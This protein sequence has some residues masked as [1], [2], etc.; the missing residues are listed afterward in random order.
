MEVHVGGINIMDT[1]IVQVHVF[2]DSRLTWWEVLWYDISDAKLFKN[3]RSF[4]VP[5]PGLLSCFVLMLASSVP[6]G[7]VR[8]ARMSLQMFRLCGK[9]L[10][11]RPLSFFFFFLKFIENSIWLWTTAAT[12]RS[13]VGKRE[14]EKNIYT[15]CLPLHVHLLFKQGWFAASQFPWLGYRRQWPPAQQ[16]SHDGMC[17]GWQDGAGHSILVGC[18]WCLITNPGSQTDFPP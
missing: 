4:R 2:L 6:F 14:N 9:H 15:R 10:T 8:W 5:Q 18:S 17:L 3:G 7:T 11:C 13:E 1:C 12:C 16:D